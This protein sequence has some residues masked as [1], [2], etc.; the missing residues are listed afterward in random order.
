MGRVIRVSLLVYF[1]SLIKTSLAEGHIHTRCLVMRK[2]LN[3]RQKCQIC[4]YYSVPQ[5]I[6]GLQCRLLK[7]EYGVI[8]KED[9]KRL[10]PG[11]WANDGVIDWCTK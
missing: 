6:Y 3:S 7:D 4:M 10:Q 9:W 5:L 11:K 2:R 8:E 1:T